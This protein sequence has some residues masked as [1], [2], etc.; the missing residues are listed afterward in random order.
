MIFRLNEQLLALYLVSEMIWIGSF[1]WVHTSIDIFLFRGTM[2]L[3]DLQLLGGAK[4]EQH[5]HSLQK[6]IQF[7][8]AANI[9]FTSVSQTSNFV[10]DHHQSQVNIS[11]ILL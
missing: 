10:D 4:E 2:T 6:T 1:A 11:Q 7:D 8:Q 5:L 9:Q 3:K